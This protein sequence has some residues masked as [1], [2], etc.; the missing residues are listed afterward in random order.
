MIY[1]VIPVF[2]RWN[3][4]DQCLEKLSNQTNKNFRTVV[5]DHGS[6][7]NTA[8]HI[9]NKYPDVILLSGD[10]FMWWTAATN[11]GIKYA[12]NEGA[13]YI[14]TINNDTVPNL[15]YIEKLYNHIEQYPDVLIGASAFDASNGK[16]IYRGETLN[17]FVE[18][19]R[20]NVCDAQR[21]DNGLF[22]VS[23]FPGRGLLIPSKVF[24]AVGLFDEVKFPHY[25][26]DYDFT[27]TAARKGFDIYC[28]YDAMIGIWPEASGAN[29]LK[30][31]KSLQSYKNHLFGIKGGANLPLFYKYVFR[32]CPYYALPSHLTLGT[33]RRL[34]GFWV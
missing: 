20:K 25:M 12:L 33:L 24:S 19:S 29:Q 14:I 32:H 10:S 4:T 21:P 1:L 15:D 3:F 8:L 26:A 34:I 5:V 30:G 11:F 13:D 28:S 22:R 2:N 9:A 17:W 27:L 23:H 16:V 6:T 7:D 31:K 18:S